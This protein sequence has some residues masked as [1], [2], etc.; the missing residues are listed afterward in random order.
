MYDSFD[1]FELNSTIKNAI[2]L[3]IFVF[4]L[5]TVPLY[6]DTQELAT[7]RQ[8]QV[9]DTQRGR[10]VVAEGE[11]IPRTPAGRPPLATNRR[12]V[13]Q[14]PVATGRKSQR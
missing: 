5:S 10:A 9:F 8:S 12:S 11:K 7:P 2:R 1:S 14:Q 4:S 6:T 3:P 13:Q